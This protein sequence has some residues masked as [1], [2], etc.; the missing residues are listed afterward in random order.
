MSHMCEA[1]TIHS[2]ARRVTFFVVDK[3]TYAESLQ[4]T[5]YSTSTKVISTLVDNWS[6]NSS[7]YRVFRFNTFLG[8]VVE[9]HTHGSSLI[10]NV[11]IPLRQIWWS[12][13]PCKTS[14]VIW[15]MVTRTEICQWGNGSREEA[16]VKFTSLKKRSIKYMSQKTF[17]FWGP[18]LHWTVSRGYSDSQIRP[19]S[20]TTDL[21]LTVKHKNFL[22]GRPHLYN[23]R[24]LKEG[25]GSTAW[26]CVQINYSSCFVIWCIIC[27]SNGINTTKP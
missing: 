12:W 15:P 27:K 16:A 22:L 13:R 26:A 18:L 7:K 10:P 17:N 21:L 1:Y 24:Y 25:I 19:W 9:A 6:D 3:R 20:V 2:I 11:K 8:R 4:T 14:F 23:Q 5:L